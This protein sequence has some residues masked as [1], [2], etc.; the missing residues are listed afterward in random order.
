MTGKHSQNCNDWPHAL[1]PSRLRAEAQFPSGLIKIPE[2]REEFQLRQGIKDSKP[3]LHDRLL[4]LED[5]VEFFNLVL[6]L[7]LT[8]QEKKG[9]VAFMRVL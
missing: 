7:K 1:S 9:L 5:T 6:Q 8:E 2:H 4:T 3:Y